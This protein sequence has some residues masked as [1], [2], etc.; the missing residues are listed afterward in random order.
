MSSD[1]TH[2]PHAAPPTLL[3][4]THDNTPTGCLGESDANTPKASIR[5]YKS[6]TLI[7][8]AKRHSAPLCEHRWKGREWC[9]TVILYKYLRVYL[10]GLWPTVHNSGFEI[11]Y[12]N[13]NVLCSCGRMRGLKMV[14]WELLDRLFKKIKWTNYG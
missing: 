12:T 13:I 3:A 11:Q 4:K 14:K 6:I 2:S 1:P 5:S 10:T 8:M 9:T 7:P